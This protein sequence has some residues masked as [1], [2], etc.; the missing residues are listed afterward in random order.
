MDAGALPDRAALA[1]GTINDDDVEA[2]LIAA[3]FQFA[4]GNDSMADELFAKAALRD[5]DAA[6]SARAALDTQ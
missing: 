2:L 1:K 5:A 3:V 4:T 6:K